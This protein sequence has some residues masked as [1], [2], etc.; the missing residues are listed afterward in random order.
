MD[1]WFDRC[2]D[3]MQLSPD[4]TA[5]RAEDVIKALD[6]VLSQVPAAIRWLPPPAIRVQRQR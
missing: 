6:R 4:Q 1:Q 5:V 2:L 3:L